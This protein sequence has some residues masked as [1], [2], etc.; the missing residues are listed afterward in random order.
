MKI[1]NYHF[2]KDYTAPDMVISSHENWELLKNQKT[3]GFR[4]TEM[5]ALDALLGGLQEGEVIVVSG[6]T[7]H[8]KT[9]LCQTLTKQMIEDENYALWFSFEVPAKQFLSFMVENEKVPLFY[10]PQQLKSKNLEWLEERIKEAI[11][12]YNIKAVFI[13]H[14]HFLLDM[15][16]HNIS[17]EIGS[18]MRFL[19]E[20]AIKYSLVI[21][22]IA[23]TQKLNS[24][25]EPDASSIR[26]SS[27]VGQESDAVLV[28]LRMEE[29][30]KA[31]LKVAFTRRTGAFQKKINLIK[32]GKW[33]EEEKDDN[34]TRSIG[35]RETYLPYKNGSD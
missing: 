9:T 4:L 8:G 14:L 17:L 12:K 29:E 18:I 27:F 24:E 1:E 11:V 33:F 21:F 3:S 22:L 2:L 32:K 35:D 5:P 25:T 31:K 13:D 30:N 26:D 16:R 34:K 19:K 20:I 10:M 28:V 23:H 7:K 6:L 15:K